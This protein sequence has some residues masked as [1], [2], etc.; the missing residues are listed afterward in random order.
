MV[1]LGALKTHAT[2]IT[3]ASLAVSGLLLFSIQQ[4]IMAGPYD[5]SK[6]DQKTNQ[7]SGCDKNFGG[8]RSA[9]GKVWNISKLEQCVI[10]GLRDTRPQWECCSTLREKYEAADTEEKKKALDPEIKKIIEAPKCKA[11]LI[12]HK[13]CDCMKCPGVDKKYPGFWD[14]KNNSHFNV[15]DFHSAPAFMLSSK[16]RKGQNH[17]GYEKRN[18]G[19]FNEIYATGHRAS[20]FEREAVDITT[21]ALA[22]VGVLLILAR[23]VMRYR[24][25]SSK[26]TEQAETMINLGTAVLM[27]F[28]TL[29][30]FSHLYGYT[31]AQ[32][33]L[34]PFPTSPHNATQNP[35]NGSYD[36]IEWKNLTFIADVEKCMGVGQEMNEDPGFLFFQ[37]TG[38][39]GRSLKNGIIIAVILYLLPLSLFATIDSDADDEAES[40]KRKR[41]VVH[42]FT[43]FTILLLSGL[44][45]DLA[46]TMSG[47]TAVART[48]TNF[49][50]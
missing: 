34:S 8:E 33:F 18:L 11:D 12:T 42:I 19:G 44:M 43:F 29:V 47:T 32:K 30:V 50:P 5:C 26:K 46:A 45:I 27:I 48:A 16:K 22:G 6:Y 7:V 37:S 40:V 28:I 17:L 13:D 49:Q 41:Q 4:V 35:V 14:P 21:I 25:T 1:D 2:A 9:T 24:F 23:E 3:L 36:L 10:D 20:M 15:Y 39:H 31:Y 38:V